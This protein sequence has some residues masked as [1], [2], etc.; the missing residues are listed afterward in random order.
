MLDNKKMYRVEIIYPNGSG[1]SYTLEASNVE[2]A[3]AM[4]KRRLNGKKY[5]SVQ[6]SVCES[7]SNGYFA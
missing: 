4:A 6:I 3:K 7:C 5:H 1:Y 2:S